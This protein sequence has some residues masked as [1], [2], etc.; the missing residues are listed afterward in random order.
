MTARGAKQPHRIQR[1]RWTDYELWRL[2]EWQG[3]TYGLAAS[4]GRTY[5]AVWSRRKKLERE[6]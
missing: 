2:R 1:R 6:A 5:A 4:L 3:S